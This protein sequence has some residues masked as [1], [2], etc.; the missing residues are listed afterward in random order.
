MSYIVVN[1][2]FNLSTLLCLAV[3]KPF[4]K[5]YN[6]HIIITCYINGVPESPEWRLNKLLH[7]SMHNRSESCREHWMEWRPWLVHLLLGEWWPR[8]LCEHFEWHIKK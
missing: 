1:K 3:P 6:F 8:V 7:S 2:K 5:L 4:Q